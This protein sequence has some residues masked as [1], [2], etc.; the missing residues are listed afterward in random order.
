M[1]I[2]QYK[3]KIQLNTVQQRIN[4]LLAFMQE[5]ELIPEFNNWLN[6]K[7]EEA[8]EKTQTSVQKMS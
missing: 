6:K 7:R 4:L 1:K 8:N 3:T 2:K 5:N